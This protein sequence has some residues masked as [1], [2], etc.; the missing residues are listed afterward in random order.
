MIQHIQTF[1]YLLSRLQS[2]VDIGKAVPGGL[3]FEVQ[4][5]MIDSWDGCRQN[6]SGS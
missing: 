5:L 4:K 3:A 6:Q 1:F 2:L